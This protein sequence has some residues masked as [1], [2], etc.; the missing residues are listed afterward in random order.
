MRASEKAYE[1]IKEFEG[2]RLTAYKCAADKLTCGWGHT[3]SDVIPGMTVNETMA[4]VWLRNDVKYTED[5]ISRKLKT[6]LKQCEF[7][8]MVCTLFNTSEK[9]D[10]M[11]INHV[12]N[13]KEVYKQKV[14]LYA[15]SIKGEALKGLKIRRICERL[16]FED[17]EWL[18][19]KKE[20]QRSDVAMIK[21][22]EKQKEL[23][24]I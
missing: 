13:S 22:I 24:G 10:M 1:L 15:S 20:L 14:L 8:S 19:V 9:S 23:F 12:N 4:N 7:D 6:E 17:R 2:L 11:L 18:G 16:L 3:G 21:V 5:Q